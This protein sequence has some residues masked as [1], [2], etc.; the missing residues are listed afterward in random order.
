MM[1]LIK[2][3]MLTTVQ[4]ARIDRLWDE[5]YPQNLAGRYRQLLNGVD[6]Y[7]HHLLLD[8]AGSTAGW[9]VEFEK[10]DEIRFSIIVPAALQGKGYGRMLLDS[11]KS[12]LDEFYGWVIDHDRDIKANGE[13]YRTP[14]PFYLKNGFELLP[15]QRIEAQIISAV[16]I[17]W[18]KSA[19]A[20]GLCVRG[21]QSSTGL[22]H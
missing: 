1:Q 11:L 14:L 10:D 8:D 6:S 4:E 21:Y 20:A 7:R 5:E 3:S 13:Q 22:W 9:A 16:K 17:K 15:E 12:G 18:T 2:T 19:V